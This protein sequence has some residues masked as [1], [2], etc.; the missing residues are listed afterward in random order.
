[1]SDLPSPALALPAPDT[2]SISAL[3][4][5]DPTTLSDQDIVSLVQKLRDDRAK[6]LAGDKAAGN[7]KNAKPAK[8][9]AKPKALK[10]PLEQL[11]IED[12]GL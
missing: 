10:E 6:Y 8:A 1:M 2:E 9:G 7:V 4:D 3:F 12:L 11:S 5:R